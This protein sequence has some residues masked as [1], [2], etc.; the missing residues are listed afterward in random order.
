MF[1]QVQSFVAYLDFE[2]GNSTSGPTI[3]NKLESGGIPGYVPIFDTIKALFYKYL[4]NEMESC[5]FRV[6]QQIF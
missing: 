3:A 4:K 1:I 2:N 6:G 5:G